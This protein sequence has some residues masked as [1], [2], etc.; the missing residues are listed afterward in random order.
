MPQGIELRLDHIRYT[1]ISLEL[2]YLLFLV[3]TEEKA[4]V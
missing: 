4:K 1:Y 3:V 2:N